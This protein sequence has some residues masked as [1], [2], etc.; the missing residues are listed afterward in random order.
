MQGHGEVVTPVGHL[1][2]SQ[3]VGHISDGILLMNL[4]RLQFHGFR[5]VSFGMVISCFGKVAVEDLHDAVGVTM[6]MNGTTFARSP[7]EHELVRKIWSVSCVCA[8]VL[9]RAHARPTIKK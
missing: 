8:C 3:L 9:S 1:M 6:I 7:H 2:K 5:A 4:L